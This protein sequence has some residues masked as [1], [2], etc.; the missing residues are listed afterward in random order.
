MTKTVQSPNRETMQ[1]PAPKT[2]RLP[3][4]RTAQ[5][6]GDATNE[7]IL[8]IAQAL[9][10]G[11]TQERQSPSGPSLQRVGQFATQAV[12]AAKEAVTG[13]QR[14]PEGLREV[15]ADDIPGEGGIPGFSTTKA[16]MATGFGNPIATAQIFEER[17]GLP[18]DFDERGQPVATLKNGEQVFLNRP[19]ISDQDIRNLGME[20]IMLGGIG[21]AGAA[22]G[23]KVLGGAG[24]VIGT[25]LGVGSGSIG[26]DK[27]AQVLGSEQPVDQKRAL[28]LAGLG[29]GGEMVSPLAKKFLTRVAA[30]RNLSRGGKLTDEGREALQNAG[31]DPDSLP[32]DAI[33][34]FRQETSRGASPTEAGALAEASSMPRPV[35]LSRG[36]VTRQPH[37][38]AVEEAAEKGAMGERAQGVA[39]DFRSLQQ[40]ELRENIDIITDSFAPGRDPGQGM[41]EVQERLRAK[42]EGLKDQARELYDVAKGK[43]ASLK[44]D[45]RVGL[46]NR[47][48][49]KIMNEGYDLDEAPEFARNVI[50]KIEGDP[51]EPMTNLGLQQLERFRQRLANEARGSG[52]EA[53]LAGKMRREM[54]SYMEE[55]VDDALIAGDEEAVQSF[56]E[57]RGLWGQIKREYD[58]EK[59]VS[60]LID[61]QDGEFLLSPTEAVNT[62]FTVN[63]AVGK[64]GA[65]R[66]ARQIRR[67]LGMDSEEW[68]SLKQEAFFRLIA[69]QMSG[70][71]RD[72]NMRRIL[73]GDKF[74]TAFDNAMRKSGELMEE[75]F[76]ASELKQMRQLRNVMLRATNRRSGAANTSNTAIVGRILGNFGFLGNA[77]RDAAE[78]LFGGFLNARR[79]RQARDLL[80]NPAS[81]RSVTPGAGG[82]AAAIGG[83]N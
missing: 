15:G 48:Q 12:S 67:K 71:N 34:L 80:E 33:Q 23:R 59:V 26:A 36:D 57:A 47:L 30:S 11:A 81:R 63:N 22:I 20:G 28:V 31:I 69:K 7:E 2:V 44:P 53:A 49:T 38:Q 14:N 29:F 21:G 19:G 46:T 17:T 8:Q 73:S 75:I 39:Q 52:A 68:G 64:T 18:V 56:K 16:A 65:T 66:A 9:D 60:K 82:S 45:A 61:Q 54:D 42:Y 41:R 32:P 13:S 4:G 78:G 62:L 40:E 6:P 58:N 74:A 77:G 5:V 10:Q 43:G 37:V 24:R 3:D 25:A 55:A 76:T 70:S 1:A 79:A 51:R 72:Q 27:I 83:G 35:R 50:R